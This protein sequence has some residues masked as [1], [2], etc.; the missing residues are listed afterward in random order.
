MGED[1]WTLG[2]FTLRDYNHTEPELKACDHLFCITYQQGQEEYPV[3]LLWKR[4][5]RCFT[6][7]CNAPGL[8]L[9]K[10]MQTAMYLSRLSTAAIRILNGEKFNLFDI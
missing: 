10:D 7:T 6:R 3:M 5:K 2:L 1:V 8:K 9:P 4:G